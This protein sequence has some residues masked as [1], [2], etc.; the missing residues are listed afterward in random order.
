MATLEGRRRRR[1]WLPGAS[2]SLLLLKFVLVAEFTVR[3]SNAQPTTGGG[4]GASSSCDSSSLSFQRVAEEVLQHLAPSGD[5]YQRG[6]PDVAYNC[7]AYGRSP[8]RIKEAVITGT[9]GLGFE[10]VTLHYRCDAATDRLTVSRVATF[11]PDLQNAT[12]DCAFCN[13]LESSMCQGKS[14]GLHS[15]FSHSLT[16]LPLIPSLSLSGFLFFFS[17]SLSL[18]PT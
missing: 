10:V 17:L 5:V 3:T 7:I 2:A 6:T 13:P 8:S 12:T 14:C 16:V 4:G 18:L 15:N 9:L 11:M 1:R